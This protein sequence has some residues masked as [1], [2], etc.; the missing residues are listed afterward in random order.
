MKQIALCISSALFW[1]MVLCS[2]AAGQSDG[3]DP[4]QLGSLTRVPE[5]TGYYMATMNHQVMFDAVFDSRAWK[6]IRKSRVSK[7]M[8]RAYRKGRTTGYDEYENNMFAMYLEGYGDYYDNMIVQS[9]LNVIKP[10]F[11]NELFVYIDNDAV[12]MFEATGSLLTEFY[13]EFETDE[14]GDAVMDAEVLG[15][16]ADLIEDNF[17]DV[18]TPTMMF[19]C[20]VSDP[21]Y[22]GMLELAHNFFE[23]SLSDLRPGDQWIGDSYE[24]VDDDEQFVMSLNMNLDDIDEDEFL[25]TVENDELVD[26]ILKALRGKTVC[27]T[28]GIR[29]NIVFFG[30][31]DNLKKLQDFGSGKKLVDL[32]KLARLKKSVE[33]NA[34]ITSVSFVSEQY[35]KSAFTNYKML[36]VLMPP[37]AE[38][39]AQEYEKE[40]YGDIFF[41]KEEFIES[42]NEF[43]EEL[44]SMLMKPSM[45][46]SYSHLSEKGIESY[47]WSAATHPLMDGSTPL[48]L[49]DTVSE[50][51]IAF[52]FGHFQ[53][54]GQIYRFAAKWLSR[55][56][57]VSKI[58]ASEAVKETVARAILKDEGVDPSWIFESE[59]SDEDRVKLKKA[60][61]EAGESAKK[62]VEFTSHT[63]GV[64]DETFQQNVLPAIKGEE[65][66]ILIDQVFGPN[67]WH[68]SLDK[69]T[70]PLP[71]PSFALLQKHHDE[72]SVLTGYDS[73][74]E[75]IGTIVDGLDLPSESV[76]KL[77]ATEESL[78]SVK[79][80]E[81]ENG[82][83]IDYPIFTP[84]LKTG[85]DPSV[86]A[87]YLIGKE[88]LIFKFP[89]FAIEQMVTKRSNRIFGPA[90]DCVS[91]PSTSA[92]FYDHRLVMKTIE[93]W[94]DESDALDQAKT[95]ET[96]EDSK[97]E[98]LEFTTEELEEYVDRIWD[99]TKCWKG[100]SSRS[101]I[102]SGAAV[103]ESLFK[104]EDIP[105]EE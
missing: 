32:P 103:T 7:N 97:R 58:Q 49:V 72:K 77:V 104:F 67:P 65:T 96:K 45:T 98:L 13:R 51:T 83:R 47:Q 62:I 59:L 16:L 38:G 30:V 28:L 82:S 44:D 4:S 36:K 18:R 55:I 76:A 93:Q 22:R 39:I 6:A 54:V 60:R 29:G 26:S 42:A 25:E 21:E 23:S 8:K 105:A 19:G 10:L 88:I 95:R 15:L 79:R 68:E 46:Y 85:V 71:M 80:K 89:G 66:G 52:S 35:A 56:S 34:A 33:G 40:E 50:D 70:K 57:N 84:E 37:F 74:L 69:T 64:F 81:T 2:Q 31:A 1:V 17:Q 12:P 100:Y 3:K 20:R 73:L 53:D 86:D 101:Y 91:E 14:F 63:Y 11:E 41:T 94:I 5:T 48:S 9:V 92:T 99:F 87:K 27:V 75:K 43:F 24:V 90:A 61:E 78:E 102:E